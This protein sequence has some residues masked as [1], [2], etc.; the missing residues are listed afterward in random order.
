M[1]FNGNDIYLDRFEYRYIRDRW[2]GSITLRTNYP[3]IGDY[4]HHRLRDELPDGGPVNNI[5]YDDLVLYSRP[6][7]L[8]TVADD[9][10]D[11]EDHNV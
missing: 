6:D 2:S 11:L 5:Y 10:G 9:D 1:T 3:D 8:S 4:Y 7:I